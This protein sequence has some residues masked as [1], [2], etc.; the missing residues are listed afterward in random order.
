MTGILA[1]EVPAENIP[2]AR[3]SAAR[4]AAVQ[5]LYQIGLTGQKTEKV[6]ED[7]LSGRMPREADAPPPEMFDGALF[8]AILDAASRRKDGIE[9]IL[10]ENLDASWPL[11]RMEKLLQSLLHAGIGELLEDKTPAPVI[12]N[13]YV[14]IAH[15]FFAGKE[16]ALVNAVLDKIAKLLKP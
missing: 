2:P 3:K 4:L 7:F 1:T 15:A 10:A 16:P 12:I 8:A 6:A 5:A 9:D 11:P 13:D 14:N